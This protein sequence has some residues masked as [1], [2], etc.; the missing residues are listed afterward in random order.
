LEALR[1]EAPF[2]RTWWVILHSSSEPGEGHEA[3]AAL[4]RTGL[5]AEPR[6][7]ST[8]A[9]SELRPCLEVVVARTFPGRAEALDYQARLREAGVVAEVRYAGSLD[10]GRLESCRAGQR[11]RSLV[12]EGLRQRESPRFVESHAG[13]TFMLLGEGQES[14]VLDPVDARRGVWMAPVEEDPSG[15][16]SRRDAVD[17]YGAQGPLRLGCPVKGFAWINR[18]VPSFDYFLREPPPESPGCGQAWAFAEL[19][20][21]VPEDSW[22]FALP[23]GTRAPVF[24]AAHEVPAELLARQEELLRASPR[25]AALRSEGALHGERVGEALEEEVSSFSYGSG[26]WRVLFSVARF[27]VGEGHSTCGMDYDQ[28]LTRVVIVPPGAVERVLAEGALVG[29]E[30]VGVMDLEGDGRLELLLRGAWPEPWTRLV[31]EDGSELAG[32]VV[33]RCDSGC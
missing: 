6:R 29:D 9:F 27:R 8:T 15:L 3:L 22:G 28:Q 25:Y 21:E 11:A 24:F 31:R 5:P 23:A 7:L 12:V 26:D 4:A 19:D 16:F 17:V 30:V 10:A 2:A 33:E 18:G 32:A 14:R 1:A 20:C 13:R